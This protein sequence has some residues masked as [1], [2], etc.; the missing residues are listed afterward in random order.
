VYSKLKQRSRYIED[1]GLMGAKYFTIGELT[2]I[3]KGDNKI[4]LVVN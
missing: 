4:C 2:Y 3:E 1:D